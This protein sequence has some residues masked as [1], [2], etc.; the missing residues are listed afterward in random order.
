MVRGGNRGKV[1]VIRGKTRSMVEG[2]PEWE[3]C[4]GS[5]ITWQ[6]GAYMFRPNF[7]YMLVLSNYTFK[8]K[9]MLKPY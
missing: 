5:V 4:V 6:R 9:K 1:N 8:V 7:E 2:V 3:K